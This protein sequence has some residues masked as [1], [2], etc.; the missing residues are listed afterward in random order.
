V[1]GGLV[2]YLMLLFRTKRT[3]I[4]DTLDVWAAHGMGG[5]TGALLTGVFAEKVI[6]SAGA[7]GLL[8]G[9]PGQLLTQ[10]LAVVVTAA[11][12]F[13]VTF[14]LLKLLAFMGLR[15]TDREEA[16]GLDIAAHGEE[17]YRIVPREETPEPEVMMQEEGSRV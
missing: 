8:F 9:D 11:Y 10:L 17:G 15:V 1:I 12:S 4:D 6:N 7:N 3:Q 13:A 16:V 5:V 2:T 14:L